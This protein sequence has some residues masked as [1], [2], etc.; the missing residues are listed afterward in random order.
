LVYWTVASDLRGGGTMLLHDS[1]RSALGAVL[2][3]LDYCGST[4]E[5]KIG[6]GVPVR[7]V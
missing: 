2:K 6:C 4:T 5:R 3:L 1:W 7:S